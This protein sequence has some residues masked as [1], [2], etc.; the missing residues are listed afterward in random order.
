[1]RPSREVTGPK[2]SRSS[3]CQAVRAS[4]ISSR[5]R[6]TKFH[7]MR[8]SDSNG[9]PPSSDDPGPVVDLQAQLV[10]ARAEVGEE[11]GGDDLAVDLGG[12]VE[13]HEGVLVPGV[14]RHRRRAGPQVQL[15]ADVVGVG[16]GR[17][18]RPRRTCRRAPRPRPCPGRPGAG[19]RG[20]RRPGRRPGWPRAGPPRAGCRAWAGRRWP[21]VPSSAWATPRPAVIRLSW[22]GTDQLLDAEGVPV[23]HLALDQPGDGLQPDVGVGA[24]PGP[25]PAAV[26]GPGPCG[27]RSTRP[28]PCGGPGGA[29][30]GGRCVSPTWASR[31]GSRVRTG[32]SAASALAVPASTGPLTPR[33]AGPARPPGS[34]PASQIQAT[35]TPPAVRDRDA[36][37]RVLEGQPHG[38]P[39]EDDDAGRGHDLGPA[40]HAQPGPVVA[41]HRADAPQV[42]HPGLEAGAATWRS[43]PRPR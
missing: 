8:I 15:G 32:P 29:G 33:P 5:V 7:H 11:P 13:H 18:G 42:Q 40:G 41:D 25:E 6:A 43:R 9:V 28:R 38:E 19:R 26:G 17:R 20:A 14:E 22:P 31:L 34:A 16:P 36:D 30:P 1:M 12:A 27:R 10:P 2:R 4:A 24:D 21:P 37:H 3:P 35:P 39:G 23:Q